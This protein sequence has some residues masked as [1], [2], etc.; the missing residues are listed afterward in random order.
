MQ[1]RTGEGFQDQQVES[2][3]QQIRLSWHGPIYRL[4]MDR[5]SMAR[6]QHGKI[7]TGGKRIQRWS[8]PTKTLAWYSPG[9][10]AATLRSRVPKTRIASLL[11]TAA[12]G[13]IPR[14]QE[15]PC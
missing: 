8:E 15:H 6:L 10:V 9:R 13:S 7:T 3:G 1:R 12:S 4:S 14:I 11:V 5:M 2:S